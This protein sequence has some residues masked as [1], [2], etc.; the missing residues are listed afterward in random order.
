MNKDCRLDFIVHLWNCDE[1]YRS[2]LTECKNLNV[3]DYWFYNRL[4]L[5]SV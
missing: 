5:G 2:D 4:Y 1:L 3:I